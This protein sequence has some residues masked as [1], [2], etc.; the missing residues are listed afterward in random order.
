MSGSV[1]SEL[2]LKFTGDTSNALAAIG[3]LDAKV[4][5]SAKN[6]IASMGNMD[7]SLGKFA[8]AHPVATAATATLAAAVVYGAAKAVEAASTYNTTTVSLQNNANISSKAAQSIG[9]AFLET[10][11]KSTFSAQQI[12]SAYAPVSGMLGEVQGHALSN[13]EAMSVMSG[14]MDLAEASGNS[15][16][17]STTDLAANMKIFHVNAM[18]AGSA[19][20]DLYNTSRL[21][22]LGLDQITSA[23]NRLAPSLAGTGVTMKDTDA[24]LLDMTSK[25]GDGRKAIGALGTSLQSMIEPSSSAQKAMAGAGLSFRDA[26]GQFIGVG[27]TLDLLK[28]YLNGTAGASSAAGQ[29][30]QKSAV[31]MALFGSSGSEADSKF[32]SLADSLGK[33]TSH[34]QYMQILTDTFGKSAK[35]AD[36]VI[37]HYN[38]S[39]DSNGTSQGRA[40][41]LQAIFG[42][43]AQDMIP[44]IQGGSAAL[45]GYANQ[46]EKSG[47]VQTAA[48]RASN[49]L[50]GEQKK[51]IA[52]FK[53][54]AITIGQA[55]IPVIQTLMSIVLKIVTPIMQWVTAH[56]ALVQTTLKIAAVIGGV[57]GTF[58]LLSKALEFVR[59]AILNV[60]AAMFILE[61]DPIVAL[62]AAIIAAVV[63]L[64]VAVYELV[65]H[66][67]TVWNAIKEGANDIWNFFKKWWPL[68]LAIFTGGISLIV[69]AVVKWHDQ[70][71]AIIQKVWKDITTF[72]TGIWNGLT[73][74][75]NDTGGKLVTAI[76]DAWTSVTKNVSGEW[77]KISADLSKIWSNLTVIWN[78]TG[79]KLVTTIKESWNLIQ[80]PT[81]T[82]WTNISGF[83]GQV[84]GKIYQAAVAWF[85]QLAQYFKTIWDFISQIF[86]IAGQIEWQG[87]QTAWQLIYTTSVTIWNAIAAFF[88]AIWGIIE[89]IFQAALGVIQGILSAAWNVITAILQAAWNVITAIINTVL[90]VISG[91][92][93][94]FA[95]LVTGKW[96]ALWTDLENI[97]RTIWAGI[98]AVIQAVVAAIE[99]ILQGAWASIT[100]VAVGAWNSLNAVLS[101]IWNALKNTAQAVFTGIQTV[102]QGVWNS[103]QSATTAAWNG[104]ISAVQAAWNKLSG[105]VKAPISAAVSVINVFIGGADDVMNA[106]GLGRPIPTIKFASGGKVP[107]GWG[108]GD[109]V[110]AM[111][112]PGERVLSLSQ[113]DALGGHMG[114]DKILGLASGGAVPNVQYFASGGTAGSGN[115]LPGV[116]SGSGSGGTDTTNNSLSS[117]GG[118]PHNSSSGVSDVVH[119]A[120]SAASALA[121]LAKVFVKGAMIAAAHVVLDP[122]KAAVS[123]LPSA[124]L[125]AGMAR[126]TGLK[127]VDGAFNF[128]TQQDSKHG[129]DPAASGG[130]V[131]GQPYTGGGSVAQWIAAAL[132]AEGWPASWGGAIGV[133]IAHESGGN[134]NAINLTDSNAAAGH[135]S[136]GLMQTI[137]STFNAYRDPKLSA[138]ILDPVAN[139]VAGVRYAIA[140]YGGVNNVPGVVS[141]AHGGAYVG[142]SVG[143]MAS[144]LIKVGENGPEMIDLGDRHG[145]VYRHGDGP[146]GGDF[147]YDR[148]AHAMH[149]HAGVKIGSI[150]VTKSD[151]DPS[152]IVDEFNWHM[153]TSRLGRK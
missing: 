118:G 144:G 17:T 115:G 40:A 114:I 67:S 20:N 12:M 113:V 103:I 82:V 25:F 96:S 56:E 81:E 57:V 125:F 8:A 98:Q 9:T 84:W 37:M 102:I 34:T 79:G 70:I 97:A 91:I 73:K 32:N 148:M 140:R 147:D 51:L 133:I 71:W 11:G 153:R 141:V 54:A 47:D 83:L 58:M 129:V 44:I 53:D 46:V 4:G 137:P 36:K 45:D 93:Q 69:G 43:S 151:A 109:T 6:Y 75:W 99:A 7:S 101:G 76:K 80:G 78:A 42:K 50:E 135:P 152:D 16:S 13:K 86:T 105:I 18:D 142:Y 139:I 92:I 63:L 39:I 21:S 89:G 108:G 104:I 19:A 132:A 116:G 68:L 149:K 127:M 15:L 2:V 130:G 131:P 77:D 150:N 66:W 60:R 74:L 124:P 38:D 65:T 138:N 31:L 128:L 95:D 5:A 72:L 121:G 146:R 59:I 22:G 90:G 48:Q 30:A 28:G 41:V 122:M 87:I 49:T 126:G 100:A 64:G 1:V 26:N 35:D 10:A 61:A 145:Y 143:G 33:A 88:S 27:A 120:G 14:A 3:A 94:G 85:S 119:L 136:Q 106:V 134:P 52:A 110:P 55:L 112:T 29:A 107:G 123:A 23:V 62:I 117:L 24:L 111:L